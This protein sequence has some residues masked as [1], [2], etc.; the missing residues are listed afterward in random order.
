M[1]KLLLFALMLAL[2]SPAVCAESARDY[3]AWLEEVLPG[4]AFTDA[5]VPEFVLKNLGA[6]YAFAARTDLRYGSYIAGVRRES[7]P[8]LPADVHQSAFGGTFETRIFRAEDASGKVW[9]EFVL[10]EGVNIGVY[11][12]M[13]RIVIDVDPADYSAEIF[14]AADAQGRAQLI[15]GKEKGFSCEDES[16]AQLCFPVHNLESWGRNATDQPHSFYMDVE[17]PGEV[18]GPRWL[19]QEDLIQFTRIPIGLYL[20][21]GK[22][23]CR[24]VISESGVK[25]VVTDDPLRLYEAGPGY[26][27]LVE[28]AGK[29]LGYRPGQ[30]DFP[31]KKSVR[32]EMKWH[33]GEMYFEGG[34]GP[35]RTRWNAGRVELSDPKSLA[36]L[37]ALMNTADFSVGSVNCPS[38]LFLVIDYDDGSSADFAVATNS[39]ELFFH[40][41][42]YFTVEDD[43]LLDIFSF[44]E[45]EFYRES[46]GG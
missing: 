14:R 42:M 3:A 9:Y 20:K 33:A 2:V 44:R 30:V 27:I 16:R 37:D 21:D 17:V 36:R 29:A 43:S 40:N 22:T 26:D 31:G 34:E 13:Q 38:D 7:A 45:T 11:D 35:V 39:Y 28:M 24:L 25:G 18:A 41:G 32:A 12:G 46:M 5:Q 10:G 23:R 19:E 15:Y 8:E 6:D 4:A 1:K